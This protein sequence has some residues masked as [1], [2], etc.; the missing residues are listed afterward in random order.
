MPKGGPGSNKGYL[1]QKVIRRVPGWTHISLG[2]LL[3]G[4]VDRRELPIEEAQKLRD[5]IAAGEMV[6]KVWNKYYLN[7][8]F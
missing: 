5:T 7:Y 8:D 2:A 1:I 3:R 4:K 6:D